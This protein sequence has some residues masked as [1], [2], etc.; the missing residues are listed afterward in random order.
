MIAIAIQIPQFPA[1]VRSD[2]YAVGYG[3]ALGAEWMRRSS[4][5]NTP[6]VDVDDRMVVMT[7]C[8]TR[9]ATVAETL[10]H[11]CQTGKETNMGFYEEIAERVTGAAEGLDGA[12]GV[13]VELIASY[14]RNRPALNTMDRVGLTALAELSKTDPDLARSLVAELPM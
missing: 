11:F 3:R 14:V 8:N 13:T 7:C 5:R 2:T 6:S 10:N 9:Y 4:E 1:N 12:D